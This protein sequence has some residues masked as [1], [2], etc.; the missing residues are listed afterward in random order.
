MNRMPKF[1]NLVMIM[2]EAKKTHS[3]SKVCR[4]IRISYLLVCSF[5]MR[6][7]SHSD[8]YHILHKVLQD[9]VGYA[10]S[11]YKHEYVWHTSN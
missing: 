6:H 3:V 1:L 11:L 7:S 9:N 4:N 5:S 8:F 10:C 2:I